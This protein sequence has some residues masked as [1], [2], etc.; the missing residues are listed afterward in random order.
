MVKVVIK[1]NVKPKKVKTKLKQKQKQTQKTNININIGDTITKKRRGVSTKREQPIKKPA[2]QA[3]APVIQSF[4]QP[5]FK[6]P[7]P[8]QSTLASSILASQEKPN[9]LDKEKKE[10]SALTKALTEQNTQTEEP[11]E[12]DLE[13]V[14]IK[15]EP[16]KLEE[17]KLYESQ[18]IKKALRSQLFDEQGDDTEEINQLITES[19]SSALLSPPVN[20][21]NP[22]KVKTPKSKNT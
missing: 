18:V 16:D 9:I 7:A 8:Q 11:K 2:Q 1:K 22:F 19:R 5:I 17:L 20:I 15:K 14:R 10:Q 6:Q 4:N 13:R 12:N 3:I 21:P